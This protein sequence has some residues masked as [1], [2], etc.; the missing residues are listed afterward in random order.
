M[1]AT[2]TRNNVAEGGD[3]AAVLTQKKGADGPF[4]L[5]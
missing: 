1:V 2:R 4:L 3:G 5:R